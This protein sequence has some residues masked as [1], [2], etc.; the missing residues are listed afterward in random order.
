MGALGGVRERELLRLGRAGGER[1]VGRTGGA[2]ESA[3][4]CVWGVPG[5]EPLHLRAL[6]GSAGTQTVVL[7]CVL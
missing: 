6:A 3:S 5:H 4:C 7:V 1:G 2:C